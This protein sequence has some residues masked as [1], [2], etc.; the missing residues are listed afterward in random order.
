MSFFKSWWRAWRYQQWRCKTA[1]GNTPSRTFSA[2]HATSLA[3]AC[4]LLAA[5]DL[6]QFSSVTLKL[7]IQ[8]PAPFVEFAVA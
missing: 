1:N 7:L 4:R 2:I 3:L 5:L 8:A 6:G